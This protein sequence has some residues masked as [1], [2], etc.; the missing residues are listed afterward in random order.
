MR[1]LITRS[2][3][4]ALIA[5]LAL[6]TASCAADGEVG[7][8]QPAD[9]GGVESST[10][11]AGGSDAAE[12]DAA[13]DE[14]EAFQEEELD[15]SL[16]ASF[17]DDVPLYPGDVVSSLAALSDMT[18]QPEWNATISTDDSLETVDAAIRADYTSNGWEIRSEMDHAGGFMLITANDAYIVTV[19]Y[20]DLDGNGI[21]INYGVSS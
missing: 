17:P 5:V 9:A 16:V 8:T 6:L 4:A 18:Q 21:T 15:G 3:I 19:T 20:N 13:E 1:A 2:G 11:E 12:Q 10:E 14:A 7:G